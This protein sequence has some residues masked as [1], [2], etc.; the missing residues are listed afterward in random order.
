MV[1]TFLA[2]IELT[3]NHSE[4][5]ST[6]TY[7]AT[8]RAIADR[9]FEFF[10]TLEG[11]ALDSEKWVCSEERAVRHFT[12]NV[13]HFILPFPSVE[14][15]KDTSGLLRS[16]SYRCANSSCKSK[17]FIGLG[18]VAGVQILCRKCKTISP[19]FSKESD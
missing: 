4:F 15:V 14:I 6:K 16:T 7:R 19:P 9:E 17:L 3:L 18:E 1:S 13:Q 2:E 11:Q 10:E 8:L 5:D 12:S